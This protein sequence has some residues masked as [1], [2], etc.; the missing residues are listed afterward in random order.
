M[1]QCERCVTVSKKF[2]SKCTEI[3][4]SIVKAESKTLSFSQLRMRFSSVDLGERVHGAMIL[5]SNVIPKRIYSNLPPK[6][7]KILREILEKEAKPSVF[8]EY[9]NDEPSNTESVTLKAPVIFENGS[10]PKKQS[11]YKSV[12]DKNL[13]SWLLDSITH[14][15]MRQAPVYFSLTP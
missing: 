3:Q 14:E 4:L 1:P 6:W 11:N 13:P 9:Q 10:E 7:S 2:G 5:T 12:H 15:V 8:G